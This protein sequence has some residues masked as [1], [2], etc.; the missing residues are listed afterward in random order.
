MRNQRPIVV[1]D[2]DRIYSEDENK[3]LRR[4]IPA[5]IISCCINCAV[6]ASLFLINFSQAE[7]AE[8]EVAIFETV[9]EDN[10]KPPNLENDEIG[11][12]P[13]VQT[14]YNVD[15]IEEISVPGPVN[16]MEDVGIVGADPGMP[17]TLPPPPGLSGGSGG[18]VDDPNRVG[19][20]GL[21]GGPGGY[22]GTW[23]SGSVLGA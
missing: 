2:V 8:T 15:R 14:N 22:G 19:R 23:V 3:R 12:D 4:V 1:V 9:V 18:G 21:I 5:W 10:S 6:I 16:A 17:K 20:G 13:D 7:D 11:L